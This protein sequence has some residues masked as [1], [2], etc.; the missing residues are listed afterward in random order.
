MDLGC[1]PGLTSFDLGKFVR[2]QGAVVARDQ[3]EQFLGFLRAEAE[4][5]GLT[6]VSTRCGPV[7]ALVPC[8]SFDAAYAPRLVDSGLLSSAD[9][10]AF[11]AEMHMR[12]ERVFGFLT[13]PTMADVVLRKRP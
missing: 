1:G 9:R 3:S 13:T 11:E 12:S 2:P 6:W 7:E 4:R 10:E 5:R 8:A